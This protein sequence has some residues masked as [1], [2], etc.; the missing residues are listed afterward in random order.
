MALT[1]ETIRRLQAAENED[2]WARRYGRLVGGEA[3]DLT[4]EQFRRLQRAGSAEQYQNRFNR[5]TSA[6]T[7]PD[8]PPPGTPAPADN[9]GAKA[10]ITRVLAEFG[11]E[12]LAE[13]AWSEFLDGKPIDQ[14]MLDMRGREE[15][16]ARFPAMSQ[17]AQQG[18]AISEAEY[19][20]FE[21]TIVQVARAAGLP[22]NFYD[23]PDD[24]A[25][26]LVANVSPSEFQDRVG[27]YVQ[28]AYEVPASD[29]LEL[30]RL[31][32]V[33]PGD[34]AAFFIDE[35]RALPRLQQQFRAAQAGGA[36]RMAGFG[37]LETAEAEALA[38]LGVDRNAAVEGF[39]QLAGLSELMQGL[40]RGETD[41]SRQQQLSAIFGGE[42]AA[43]L[44]IETRQRRR[45]AAYE[46]GGGVAATQGGVVGAGTARAGR[47]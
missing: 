2:A 1:E 6:V 24:F 25:R 18:R 31:Y 35:E 19:I 3:P 8:E 46:A 22:Q 43:Q 41:I 38:E 40:D 13:W 15:Y 14:I 23:S 16:I 7:P 4:D 21:K 9:E 28:A 33:T 20:G 47:S 17:L 29:R 11:L 45:Q 37:F 30:E 12:S 32:G 42:R 5:F 26:L 10:A 44:E 39:G 27:M 34:I 36:A